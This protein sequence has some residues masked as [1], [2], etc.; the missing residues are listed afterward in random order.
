[1][2]ENLLWMKKLEERGIHPEWIQSLKTSQV[3]DFSESN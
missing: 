1:M 3:A 2:D